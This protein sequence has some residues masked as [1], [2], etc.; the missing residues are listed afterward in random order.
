MLRLGFLKTGFHPALLF[1]GHRATG[2]LS[3][4]GIIAS[5]FRM[6]KTSAQSKRLPSGDEI[7][8]RNVG[9]GKD[10]DVSA[11]NVCR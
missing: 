6:K 5:H 9:R 11:V 4:F 7:E 3:G 1:R 2:S 8:S 10:H